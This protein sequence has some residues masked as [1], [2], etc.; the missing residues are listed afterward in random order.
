MLEVRLISFLSFEAVFGLSQS[1]PS[2]PVGVRLE[3]ADGAI[4]RPRTPR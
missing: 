3:L 2:T 1:A 4:I